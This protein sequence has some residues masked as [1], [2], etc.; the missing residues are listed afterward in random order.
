MSDLTFSYL[1]WWVTW[2]A[3][4]FVV[5]L[6]DMLLP[7]LLSD[8]TCFYLCC[9][10]TWHALTF[11]VEWLDMLLLLL[12]SDLTCSYLCC[13]VTWMLLPLLVSDLTCSYLCC[14]V[15]WHAPTIACEWLDI[16]I[17]LL[18]SDLTCSFL[19]WRVT[20][21]DPTFVGEWLDILL[22]LLVSD[23]TFSYLCWWV[24]W[25]APTFAGEWLDML[26]PL[27]VS[28]LTCS[29]NFL[30]AISA[31]QRLSL[32]AS[33]SC[34]RS[35]IDRGKLVTSFILEY[36][37]HKKLFVLNVCC[38]L[39]FCFFA[40]VLCVCFCTGHFVRVPL[41][42]TGLHCLQ[43]SFFVTSLQFILHMFY[44]WGLYD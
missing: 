22:P 4:T 14:W 12:V 24:T 31:F 35:C 11:V 21:H 33:N 34:I 30:A 42:L 10:V 36:K 16:L 17:L 3:P 37:T 29:T 19:C 2:H 32:S 41:N 43:H 13:W 25:H 38:V 26:L 20:W 27:L 6:L 7:L 23:L 15:T 8:L 9:W 1:C 39:V 5:E 44:I 18:V 28:D 40:A